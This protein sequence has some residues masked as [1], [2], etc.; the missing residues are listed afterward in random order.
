MWSDTVWLI[1]SVESLSPVSVRIALEVSFPLIVFVGQPALVGWMVDQNGSVLS[2][3]E[4]EV[5][6]SLGYVFVGSHITISINPEELTV[7]RLD[8]V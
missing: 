2:S 1:P 6:P 8:G 5:F 7:H 3:V 4:L